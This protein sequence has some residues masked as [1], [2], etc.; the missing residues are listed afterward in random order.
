[1]HYGAGARQIAPPTTAHAYCNLRYAGKIQVQ[2]LTR[3]LDKLAGLASEITVVFLKG[4]AIWRNPT[5]RQ[6]SKS[7]SYLG[8]HTAWPPRLP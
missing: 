4:F 3:A 1:M 2:R 7:K 5:K 6:K 8:L